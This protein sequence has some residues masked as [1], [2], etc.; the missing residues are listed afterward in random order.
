MGLIPG[1]PTVESFPEELPEA[2]ENLSEGGQ[3]SDVTVVDLAATPH[4]ALMELARASAEAPLGQLL[5]EPPGV[6][7]EREAHLTGAPAVVFA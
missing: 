2:G 1:D 3:R 7:P 6:L 5:P 4:E